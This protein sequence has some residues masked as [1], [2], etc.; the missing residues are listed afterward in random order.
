MTTTTKPAPLPAGIVAADLKAPK[1]QSNEQEGVPWD[2]RTF[3]LWHT[4]AFG[5]CIP[6]LLIGKARGRQSTDR[7]YA[8]TL[9]GKVCRIGMGPH[10]TQT[11]TVYVRQSR[12]GDLQKYLDLRTAGSADAGSIR[13]RISTRR[14]RGQQHRAAGDT[15]WRW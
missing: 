12:L 8:V 11:V 1:W 7:T 10:V 6:T 4:A 2:A 14:A 5:W 9:D 13:D 3:D 15:H